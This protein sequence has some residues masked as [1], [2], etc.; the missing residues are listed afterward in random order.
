MHEVETLPEKAF[1]VF[2]S[3]QFVYWSTPCVNGTG[4]VVEVPQ[5]V[6]DQNFNFKQTTTI[7]HYTHPIYV[8]TVRRSGLRYNG[9]FFIRFILFIVKCIRCTGKKKNQIR[10]CSI[11]YID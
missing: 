3:E 6:N 11:F 1:D 10:M 8:L 2:R 5:E 7:I 4:A 9:A